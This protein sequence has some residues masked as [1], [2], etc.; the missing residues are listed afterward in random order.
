MA[1][2]DKNLAEDIAAFVA[3][4]PWFLARGVVGPAL[5]VA[6]TVLGWVGITIDEDT[7]NAVLDLLDNGWVQLVAVGGL[8]GSAIGLWGRIFATKKVTK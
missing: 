1:E 5:G 7:R 2:E 3:T 8:L 6:A 4:K